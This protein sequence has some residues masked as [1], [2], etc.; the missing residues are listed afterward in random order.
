MVVDSSGEISESLYEQL[1]ETYHLIC[2]TQKELALDLSKT[3]PRLNVLIVDEGALPIV[4]DFLRVYHDVLV[5]VVSKDAAAIE[6]LNAAFRRGIS[7]FL[8]HPTQNSIFFAM[9]QLL[10]TR[11]LKQFLPFFSQKYVSETWETQS[12]SALLEELCSDKQSQGEAFQMKDI[13]TFFPEL[14]KTHIP[15]EVTLP[16]TVIQEGISSFVQ[17]MMETLPQC[18]LEC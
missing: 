6:T 11:F 2:T 17:K 10:E 15:A 14:K 1:E 8:I 9:E 12:K 18:V 3:E 13:Y 4:R 5:V 16:V 7:D